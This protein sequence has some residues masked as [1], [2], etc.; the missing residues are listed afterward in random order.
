MK[1]ISGIK[2]ARFNVEEEKVVRGADGLCIACEPGEPGELLFPIVETDKSTTFAGYE[3][4]K[5]CCF[6]FVQNAIVSDAAAD[7]SSF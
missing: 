3:D 5:V 7:E 6:L 2:F 4:P 1:R